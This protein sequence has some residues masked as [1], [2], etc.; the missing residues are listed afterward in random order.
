MVNPKSINRELFT[1]ANTFSGRGNL[2]QDP[3]LKQVSVNDEL[4][5]VVELRVY[6]D[7]PVPVAEGHFQ[8]RGG[9]WLD[10]N[11]WGPRAEHVARCLAKGARVRV[12]GTLWQDAWE[13]KDSGEP[14]RRLRLTAE[15]VDL[16]LA[17]VEAVTWRARMTDEAA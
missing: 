4:R 10:A 5:P 9:F 8:D 17:R 13:D 12:E 16:D 1:M 6:I 11:L 2:G 7:R 14:R 15:Q 3:V